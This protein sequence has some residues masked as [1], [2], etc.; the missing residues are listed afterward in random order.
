MSRRLPS[1][2]A[3]LL[4][5]TFTPAPPSGFPLPFAPTDPRAIE[6]G[7]VAEFDALRQKP[8]AEAVAN[9][10]RYVRTIAAATRQLTR[11]NLI[12]ASPAP[13]PS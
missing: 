1:A 4:E 6:R 3:D 13:V 10:D 8:S 7:I 11:L 12:P 2:Y 9:V 5:Q